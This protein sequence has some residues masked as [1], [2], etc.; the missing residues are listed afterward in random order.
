[1][2]LKGKTKKALQRATIQAQFPFLI[3]ITNEDLG[4]FYYANCD[5]DISYEGKTF[6][7]C[8][9]ELSPPQQTSTTIGNASISISSVDQEWIAKIRSTAKRSRLRF[10][11][12]I[13]Y[14]ED[15]QR[16]VEPIEDMEFMLT[17][18]TWTETTIEWSMEFDDKMDII[19][20]CDIADSWSCAGCLM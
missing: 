8:Y 15:G 11:S 13:V 6:K 14:D 3:E 1:M 5:E 12:T 18:A 2:S 17:K 16:Y 10:I 19:M 9:F 7:A 20:P 4:T